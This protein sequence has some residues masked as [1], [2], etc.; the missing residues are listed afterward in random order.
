MA[1][2]IQV[3]NKLLVLFIIL[4]NFKIVKSEV[5]KP[6]DYGNF[7]SWNHAKQNSDSRNLKKFLYEIDLNQIDKNFYEEILLQSVIFGDWK[8]SRLISEKILV[9]DIN[10]TLANFYMT[11]EN[12]LR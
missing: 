4:F 8:N 11:V 3:C 7:L 10:N 1:Q 2:I 9:K 6:S 12:F 5:K